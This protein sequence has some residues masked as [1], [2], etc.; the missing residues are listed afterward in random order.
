MILE[1]FRVD[2]VYL[3]LAELLLL[4]D[5]ELQFVVVMDSCEGCGTMIDI[6]GAVAK[7]EV[8]DIDGDDL[9]QCCVGFSL[10]LM[11]GDDS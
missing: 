10:F 9:D 6:V 2:M 7:I 1:P 5:I 3:T 11:F 8:E 4:L